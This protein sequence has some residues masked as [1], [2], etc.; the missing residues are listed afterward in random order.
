MTGGQCDDVGWALTHPGDHLGKDRA[1]GGGNH[2]VVG[3]QQQ[4]CAIEHGLDFQRMRPGTEVI[5][6]VL[7]HDEARSRRDLRIEQFQRPV[8]HRHEHDGKSVVRQ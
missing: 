2:A 3:E 1:I 8:D 7:A 6:D 4:A 5:A